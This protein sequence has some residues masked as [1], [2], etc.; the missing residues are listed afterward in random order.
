[1]RIEPRIAIGAGED[2]LAGLVGGDDETD[3]QLRKEGW[4]V[5]GMHAAQWLS[6]RH[7]PA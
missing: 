6:M 7:T 4:Q 3:L 1:M 2:E 5:G